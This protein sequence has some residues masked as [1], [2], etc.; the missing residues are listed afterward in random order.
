ME[1]YSTATMDINELKRQYDENVTT[2]F[3]NVNVTY[4]QA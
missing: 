3:G 4:S 2:T 1:F